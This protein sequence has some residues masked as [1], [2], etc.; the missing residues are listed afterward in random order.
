MTKEELEREIGRVTE[1]LKHVE[2]QIE[3]L[4]DKIE[5]LH[6]KKDV[7]DIELGRFEDEFIDQIEQMAEEA[8]AAPLPAGIRIAG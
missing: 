7:L 1:Q 8:T 4:N 6:I 3:E 2:A 5:E